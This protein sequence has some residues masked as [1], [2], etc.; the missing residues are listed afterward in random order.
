MKKKV[1]NFWDSTK[2]GGEGQSLPSQRDGDGFRQ[3]VDEEIKLHPKKDLSF[4]Q[5][6]LQI[7][8]SSFFYPP[9]PSDFMNISFDKIKSF[10][11]H[12]LV[13][14]LLDWASSSVWDTG[15]VICDLLTLDSFALRLIAH[16]WLR[17]SSRVGW[18]SV[19]RGLVV[20][21]WCSAKAKSA[22]VFDKL[23]GVIALCTYLRESQLGPGWEVLLK[24]SPA[25]FNATRNCINFRGHVCHYISFM[26]ILTKLMDR[27]QLLE[28]FHATF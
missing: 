7:F 8:P 6:M 26:H 13:F 15:T 20:R 4:L 25:S 10:T 11:L 18:S 21:W 28:M 3:K 9:S 27:S 14:Y 2:P 16:C 19:A 17:W 5:H 23:L 12:I 22:D 24:D 1:N